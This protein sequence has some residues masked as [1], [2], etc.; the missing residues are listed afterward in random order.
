[1]IEN[2]NNKSY[3]A[4][5][6]ELC[7]GEIT[8]F[9]RYQR[10]LEWNIEQVGDVT[11]EIFELAEKTAE[12]RDAHKSNLLNVCIYQEDDLTYV[13][14]GHSRMMVFNIL[15]MAIND[16]IAA[17]GYTC[18]MLKT[19][20][21][22]Y[23]REDSAD[24]YKEFVQNHRC[25]SK[26]GTAYKH[27]YDQIVD[28]DRPK[29]NDIKTLIDIVKTR[30]VVQVK[31]CD[32][33]QQAYKYFEQINTG[34][35]VLTKNDV[36]TSFIERYVEE[37][38]TPITYEADE[39]A[40]VIMSYYFLE[41][42][43]ANAVF[44]AYT[45]RAFMEDSVVKTPKLFGKF[46][47]YM[48]KID[49]FHSTSW[50]VILNHLN[51]DKTMR[52]AFSLA[53]KNFDL[54]GADDQVNDFLSALI[55]MGIVS[56][57]KSLN[58]GSTMN[59]FFTDLMIDIGAG[60]NIEYLLDRVSTWINKRRSKMKIDIDS[61]AESLD[62]LRDGSKKAIMNL[63]YWYYNRSA[64][65]ATENYQVEHS[66]PE[67]AGREWVEDGWP[68]NKEE[69]T[70]LLKCIGN[71]FLISSEANEEASNRSLHGKKSVY[72]DFFNKHRGLKSTCNYF[73]ADEFDKKRMEY[74][75][76]RRKDYALFLSELHC[77]DIMIVK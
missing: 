61:F 35:K 54:T 50:Y 39:L 62:D 57:S 45:L 24:T 5:L 56:S 59:A 11:N 43:N 38:A 4:S 25:A 67:K 72:V 33:K 17:K 37:Y 27:I 23:L 48:D 1:M 2:I 21:M 58:A 70:A 46:Q 52:I 32:D 66:Y 51:S 36:I 77:G 69:K 8:R 28:F 34:G 49:D 64:N 65:L 10:P 9:D 6:Y 30:V 19:F 53:G 15:V 13:A 22:N 63:A 55:V 71:Q 73:D 44:N 16:Y 41:H 31:P 60:K 26:Y 29:R 3:E 20:N 14:D 74:A 12:Y 40:D 76:K 75:I 7:S 42:N 68:R 18:P 47:E